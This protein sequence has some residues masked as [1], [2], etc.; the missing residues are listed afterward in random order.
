MKQFVLSWCLFRQNLNKAFRFFPYP[1][2][3]RCVGEH[4]VFSFCVIS[5][6][7]FGKWDRVDSV[8]NFSS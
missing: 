7:L 4:M 3:P 6:G 8:K 2:F 1:L 5:Q